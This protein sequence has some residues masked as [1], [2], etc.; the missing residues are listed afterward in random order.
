MRSFGTTVLIALAIL[1]VISTCSVVTMAQSILV[2]N[3]EWVFADGTDGLNNTGTNDSQFADNVA[4]WL[5]RQSSSCAPKCAGNILLL[6]SSTQGLTYNSLATQLTK[7]GYSVQGPTANV[8]LQATLL[9]YTAVYLA[10]PKLCFTC[11]S[12]IPNYAALDTALVSYVNQ[13]SNPGNVFIMAGTQCNDYVL[14][15]SFLNTF[16]LSLAPS[17][18]NIGNPHGVVIAVT[19]FQNQVPNG[20]AL[21]GSKPPVNDIFIEEGEDVSNIGPAGD[22]VE[23][24]D[25]TNNGTVNGLYGAW[26]PPG[27]ATGGTWTPLAHQPSFYTGAAVLLTDGTVLAHEES[28]RPVLGSNYGNWWRLT[29]DVY[30]SYIN[31]TW[32]KVPSTLPS[33]YGVLC[34]SLPPCFPTAGLSSRAESTTM[35]LVPILSLERS[36]RTT[37]A[38]PSSITGRRCPLLIT[39]S[40]LVMPRAWFCPT[41]HLCWL[42]AVRT[43]RQR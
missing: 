41:V 19:P 8:P 29:P 7:D 4:A 20:V 21:F 34:F 42:I 13:S 33:P 35:G 36:S 23:I 39:G 32:S 25:Y 24:F 2:S 3:D 12:D 27:P 40:P 22:G 30:G 11:G 5:T 15:N 38:T 43:M 26:R 31:G 9:K 17:C 18:N 14:W 10:G 1:L 16:N 6:V 37:Q 28:D